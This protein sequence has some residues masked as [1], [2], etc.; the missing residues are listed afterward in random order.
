MATTSYLYLSVWSRQG[1]WASV[2]ERSSRLLRV[3]GFWS[4]SWIVVGV[5]LLPLLP[6]VNFCRGRPPCGNPSSWRSQG[7]PHRVLVATVAGV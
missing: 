6:G 4:A 7:Y 2:L 1:P 3:E 5:V